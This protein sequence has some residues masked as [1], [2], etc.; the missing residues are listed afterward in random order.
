MD[1]IGGAWEPVAGMLQHRA[2][3]AAA[4]LEG[5]LFVCGGWSGQQYLNTVEAFNA[6]TGHWCVMPPMARH[7]AA[8]AAA[9]VAGCLY[10]C[11]GWD[12]REALSEVECYSPAK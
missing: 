1:P 8:A 9:T 2:A 12:G 4:T 6:T 3:A 7:A 5:R 11:G 10:V